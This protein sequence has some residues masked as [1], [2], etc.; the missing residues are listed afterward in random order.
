MRKLILSFF[1][2]GLFTVAVHAQV[3]IAYMNPNT[4]LAQ[5]EEVQIVE[6]EINALITQRD[7]EIVPKANALRQA[8]ADYDEIRASLSQAEQ[9]SREA[10]LLQRNEDLENERE[11]YLNEV[12]QKRAS[13][14]QPIIEKMDNAIQKIA[15]SMEIDIVLNEGTS[16]G[17]F[18]I[19]YANDERLNITNLVLE[20]LK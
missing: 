14:M 17:E 19:F 12:R 15:T 6:D 20:E 7:Q 3:K 13:M 8:F 16:Y 11:T 5:L 4:V 9:Q 1:V 10:D 18:L 2:V